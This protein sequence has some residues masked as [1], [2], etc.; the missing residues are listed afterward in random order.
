MLQVSRLNLYFPRYI[1]PFRATFLVALVSSIYSQTRSSCTILHRNSTH[2]YSYLPSICTSLTLL[3]HGRHS[4]S[5][6]RI[7]FTSAARS[8]NFTNCGNVTDSIKA[9]L[10]IELWTVVTFST[11]STVAGEDFE[12]AGVDA[13]VVTACR[14]FASGRL[15]RDGRLRHGLPQ[16]SG[17]NWTTRFGEASWGRSQSR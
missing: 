9:W 13:A 3:G 12:L 11:R 16:R 4:S 15:R 10:R 8:T 1:L 2:C 14:N 7:G 6:T 17:C 5:Q